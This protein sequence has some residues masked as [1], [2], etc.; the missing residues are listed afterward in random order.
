MRVVERGSVRHHQIA[1]GRLKKA[2]GRRHRGGA[3]A[4]N[5]PIVVLIII[6]SALCSPAG[7]A[8]GQTSVDVELVL[9]VDVSRSMDQGELELQRSGYVAA[10]MHE[11]VVQ[12][13]QSGF[14]GRVAITYVEW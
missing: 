5:S 11:E 13:I 2:T 10:L 8:R 1:E 9:A 6:L 4:R 3:M 12:A 7:T 14:H